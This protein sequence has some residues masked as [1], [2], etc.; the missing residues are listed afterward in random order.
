MLL[1]AVGLILLP[2][3]NE[4]PTRPAT[5]VLSVSVMDTSGPPVPDVEVRIVPPGLAAMTDAHGL[6]LFE[7]APGE[8]F[9][10]AN[11]C[12][13]G[14]AFIDYHVPVTVTAGE[15]ETVELRSCLTCQ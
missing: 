6:A 8:Y 5:G 9:V 12:C 10:V 11:L 14:P 15:T 7:L 3:C 4:D 2:G 13:R 1:L